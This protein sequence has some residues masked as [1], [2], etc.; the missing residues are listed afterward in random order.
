MGGE[1]SSD[2]LML[3]VGEGLDA[4][5]WGACGVCKGSMAKSYVREPEVEGVLSAIISILF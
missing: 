3:S 5:S 1:G 2:V 4:P